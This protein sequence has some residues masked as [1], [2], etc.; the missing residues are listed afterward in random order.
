MHPVISAVLI[1]AFSITIVSL[2]FQSGFPMIEEQKQEW[3]FEQGKKI[4][5]LISVS[6]SD[7]LD[8]PIG[9][10]KELEMGYSKGSLKFSNNTI[11]FSAHLRDYNRTFK[12]VIFNNLEIPP[13]KI[14]L[15]L[16]KIS[17]NEMKV[18]FLN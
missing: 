10:F 4:V 2:V 8:E 17:K 7:L 1:M 6:V 9:S 18:E 16:T 5:N 14:K 13:G 3:E 15:K 11:S 12:K